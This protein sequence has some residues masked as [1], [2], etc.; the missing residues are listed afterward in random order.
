MDTVKF[1]V[2]SCEKCPNMKADRFYTADSFE[3]C[4]EWK[5][6]AKDDKQIAIQDWNDKVPKIPV[7]CPL[8]V[9]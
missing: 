7:W 3:H 2:V 4:Y 6:T 9:K 1:T 8:R 5:C